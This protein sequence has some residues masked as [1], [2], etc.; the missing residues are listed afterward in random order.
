[1]GV[2]SGEQNSPPLF[3]IALGSGFFMSLLGLT[4]PDD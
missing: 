2:G 3:F 1:M 4:K